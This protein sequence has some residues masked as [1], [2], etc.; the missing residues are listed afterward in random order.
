MITIVV[1]F[2]GVLLSFCQ[3][4][5]ELYTEYVWR[6]SKPSRGSSYL[7]RKSSK[8]ESWEK[9]FHTMLMGRAPEGKCWDHINGDPFDNRKSN[10]R[11]CTPLENNY[12]R[13]KKTGSRTPSR[14][15]GVSRHSD[16]KGWNAKVTSSGVTVFCKYFRCEEDAARARD[17]IAREH[18]GEFARLNFPD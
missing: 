1:H 12:N 15:I 9:V 16:G 4:G 5:F 3:D 10:L 13:G 8:G 14:F 11:V 6:I 17:S 7:V 18:F 2:Q